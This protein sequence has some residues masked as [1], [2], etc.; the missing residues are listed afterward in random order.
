[1]KTRALKSDLILLLVAGIWGLAFVAQRVGMEHVG[2]FTFNGIRFGLGGLSL[3]PFLFFPRNRMEDTFP[4]GLLPSGMLAGTVLFV[5][6]SLQQ[7]GIVYTTAGKAGFITG[8]YVVIVPFLGLFIKAGR[9]SAGTWV[10][11][12]M[13]GT[14]MYLLSVTKD[15]TIAFGDLLVFISAVCFA[16]H[17]LIIG[18]VSA[19]FDTV[20]LSLIQCLVCTVLS[21][22]V[23]LGFETLSLTSIL[24]TAFPLFYGGVLS[25]GVAYSLQIHGQKH[26]PPSHAAI[27]CSLESVVA[28]IGGWIILNEI[29]SGRAVMGCGL[30]LAGMLVSQLYSIQHSKENQ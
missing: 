1:M 2:P 26:S 21:L 4:T 25:V 7:V 22:A 5:G 3:L 23:A 19:R 8:L 16:L 9:T 18:R 27:I 6:I 30:M 28:V 11:A 15:M 10:G 13:A 29:L 24:N 20:R 12:F 14:G 17:I